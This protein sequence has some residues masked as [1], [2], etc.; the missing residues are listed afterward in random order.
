MSSFKCGKLLKSLPMTIA[1]SHLTNIMRLT[2]APFCYK[3][4][5]LIDF[6]P[7]ELSVIDLLKLN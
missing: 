6:F 4:T 2:V 3:A 1:L 7:P 5:K